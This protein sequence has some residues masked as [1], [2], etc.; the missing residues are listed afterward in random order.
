M[1]KMRYGR[2][3]TGLADCAGKAG[4]KGAGCPHPGVCGEPAE[5]F[6]KAGY[7]GYGQHGGKTECGSTAL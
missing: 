1:L 7:P 4:S 2:H 3:T 6:G 5:P